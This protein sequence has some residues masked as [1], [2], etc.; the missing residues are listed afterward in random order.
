MADRKGFSLIEALLSLVFFFMIIVSSLEFFGTTRTIFFR[1]KEAQ[2]TRAGAAAALEKVRIDLLHAGRGLAQPISLGI[3]GGIEFKNEM[4][5]LFIGEKVYSLVSDLAPGQT[6]V[7]LA[8]TDGLRA[9]RDIC[10]FD[11]RRGEVLG[12]ES[13][14]KDLI[15]LSLPPENF[16]IQQEGKIVLLQKISLYLERESSVLRRKVNTSPAQPLLE[17]V[18]FFG[19]TYGGHSNL[20]QA[21]IGLEK[22]PEKIHEI[23]VLLKNI[24][25]GKAR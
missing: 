10:V 13:V 16:Y 1:L 11:E 19:F 4:L 14:D 12:I 18:R 22:E 17:G 6:V 15:R 5:G 7:R 21:R 2:E 8:D 23:S 3:L 25:L 9:G 24:A 20:A